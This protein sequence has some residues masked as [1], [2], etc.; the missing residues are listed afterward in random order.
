M[1]VCVCIAVWTRMAFGDKEEGVVQ[2]MEEWKNPT[3]WEL[4]PEDSSSQAFLRPGGSRLCICSAQ[5]LPRVLRPHSCQLLPLLFLHP[6]LLLL[7]CPQKLLPTCLDSLLPL[8]LFPLSVLGTVAKEAQLVRR[9]TWPW[10]SPPRVPS[11]ESQTL[12]LSPHTTQEGGTL[13]YQA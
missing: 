3:G 4:G 13:S 12:G 10:K 6:F 5:T 1:H 7:G 11:A 2:L 9:L 8:P